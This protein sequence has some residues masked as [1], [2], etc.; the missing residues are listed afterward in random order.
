MDAAEQDPGAPGAQAGTARPLDTFLAG[1]QAGMLG[2]LWM[3]VW[4]GL[5]ATW[6]RRSFWAPENLLAS[7]FHPNGIIAAE[8]GT[9]TISGLALYL[10]TY[11]LVGGLFAMVAGKQRMRPA[12]CV[13]LG[14]LTGLF[15]YYFSFHLLWRTVSPSIAFLNAERPAV[16]GHVIYGLVIGRFHAYL[17]KSETVV[18]EAVAEA[19]TKIPTP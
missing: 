8:F 11:C 1:L 18:T 19:E 14:V 17:P 5:C 12:R 9:S 16:L 2:V 10:L 15:W 4:T 3:L 6:V 7:V 13:L